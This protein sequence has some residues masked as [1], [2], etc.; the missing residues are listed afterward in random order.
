MAV[1][2]AVVGA[3]KFGEVHLKIFKQLEMDGVAELKG[4]ST[5]KQEEIDRNEPIYGVKGYLDYKEMLEKE[6]LDAITVVT[7]DFLHREIAVYAANCGKHVLCEKP[8]DVT[9]EGCDKMIEAARKNNVILQVD[10]HK[11]YDPDHMAVEAGVRAGKLGDI[12]YGH[13]YMEDRIEV[14]VD[15]FPH[16]APHGSPLWFLGSHFIDLMR[17]IIKSD[18]ESVWAKGSKK[19]LLGEFGIDMYD[20]V[21]ALVAFKNGAAVSFDVSWILPRKFEA[22]VNQGMRIVGTKGV[23]EVDSQ[24]RG[25]RSCFEDEGMRTWNNNFMREEK[26]KQGRTIYRGYGVESI[27]DFVYNVQFLKNGGTLEQLAG[28]YPSGEDG[29]EVTR[30]CAGIAKSLETGEVVKL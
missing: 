14:P 18:G 5:I 6:D 29:R 8:L 23:W 19:K 30:I 3:G 2:I 9:V 28:K 7:P 10:F 27:A 25:D 4:F 26:D 12:L 20:S 21:S 16:W 22:I 1:K 13:C 24:D 11:R 17:W 15:W